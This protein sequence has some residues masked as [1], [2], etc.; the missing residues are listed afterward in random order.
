MTYNSLCKLYNIKKSV[1]ELITDSEKD[2][3]EK[4]KNL[5]EIQEDNFYK[6]VKAFQDNRVNY[7]HFYWNTGYG[8]N[9]SGREVLEKVYSHY[10]KTEDSIVRPIIASGT[11]ALYL[12]V[13]G[14][15]KYGDEVISI[16]GDPY[17]TMMTILG[18]KGNESNNLKELGIKYKKIDLLDNKDFDYKEIEKKVSE[19]TKMVMIQRSMGYSSRR[20]LSIN[21]IKKAIEF[22]KKIN[23]NIIIMVDN[24]YGEFVENN[25]PSHVGADVVVGSLIKNPGGGLALS[26]G[27]ITGKQELIDRISNR[28]TSPGIGKEVGLMFDQTRN[29][30]QGF[31]LAPK[32]TMSALKGSIL[33]SH[34]F[35]K[36][37][38]KVYP[39][40]EE[41]RTDII[42]AIV[43]EEKDKLISFCEE[44]QHA[45]PVD[46][47]VR[48]IPWAM[49]GYND[50][51]IMAAGTFVQGASIELSADAPIREPYTGF[52]QGG[53]VYEHSK[54]AL[55][56]I[57]NKLLD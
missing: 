35:N 25:E 19:N 32:T 56:L 38:Y 37:G 28:M 53:L 4:F 9:D 5:D 22:V 14:L 49:P 24:C 52:L 42:Q 57:L 31:F 46:S 18:E 16:S 20:S 12:T 1:I 41:E 3:V 15:L 6:V 43:F 7:S 47:N 48:P 29:I 51:V 17:D 10:F 26:G 2:L 34:V 54:L 30:L 13:S 8:Y 36:L 11:H 27:Y 21:A 50:E 44:V 39:K 23:N 55:S 33:F 45:S 40:P